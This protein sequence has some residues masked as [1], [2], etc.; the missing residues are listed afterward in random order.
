MLFVPATTDM[1]CLAEA[2]CQTRPIPIFPV[3]KDVIYLSPGDM[4]R[5]SMVYLLIDLTI[6]WFLEA[7]TSEGNSGQFISPAG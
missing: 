5:K 7:S 6:G 1:D 3:G 2:V 4:E